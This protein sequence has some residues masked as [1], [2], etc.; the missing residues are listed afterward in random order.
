MKIHIIGGSGSGKTYLANKL[1]RSNNIEHYDLDDIQWDNN[2]ETY[3][4]K[5]AK[6]ERKSMLR[7]ILDKDDWIIEG[8]YYKWVEEAF[9]QAD[10]IYV[11]DMPLVLTRIRIIKRF[12][13]RKLGRER[14]KKETLKSLFGLIKWTKEYRNVDIINIREM[15]S[16][17][18]DKVYYITNKKQ[19]EKV[20][21]G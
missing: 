6:E 21:N 3:G 2:S 14:G 4:V 5:R 20:V 17:Y 9:S 8:V 10:V 7:E 11:L 16:E 15:L 12:I 1:A 18:S 13:K 19:F